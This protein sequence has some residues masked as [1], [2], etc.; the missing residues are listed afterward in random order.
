MFTNYIYNILHCQLL[1]HLQDAL[2]R[3]MCLQFLTHTNYSNISHQRP[4]RR[5]SSHCQYWFTGSM[6]QHSSLQLLIYLT[7]TNSALQPHDHAPLP[8]QYSPPPTSPD[9]RQPTHSRGMRPPLRSPNG[10]IFTISLHNNIAL[11]LLY[12]HWFLTYNFD[13]YSGR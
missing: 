10:C 11:V 13:N 2:N 1:S 5:I 4:A 3:R 8:P 6:W 12:I 9:P 7:D